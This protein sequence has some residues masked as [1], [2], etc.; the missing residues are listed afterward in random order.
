MNETI[1]EQAHAY[2]CRLFPGFDSPLMSTD[3]EFVER[4][5]NFAFGEVPASD[6]LDDR[7]RLMAILAALIGSQATD[8]FKAM[9]KGAFNVGVTPVEVKELVYQST[10]YVGMGR[11]LPFLYAVNELLEHR[12]VTLPLEGQATTTMD[13][14]LEA[15]A[16]KQ[17]DL[18]GPHMADFYQS[19]PEETRHINRWLA[20][21]CFGDYYTR[22]GLDDAQRE[23]ITFCLLIA[24]GGCE[25][26]VVSHAQANMRVGNDRAFLIKVVS[27][28]LPYIGYPRSLNALRCIDE[29]AQAA[30]AQAAE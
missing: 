3:P 24:Q 19:G 12:L 5:D 25:P 6:D 21:N 11:M 2:R 20:E 30:T 16:Q 13:T 27:Q 1:N 4:M 23:M 22:T 8:L 9:V 7:T 10:P 14:R 17:V 29:A 15:G 28:C 18:F 26:Q